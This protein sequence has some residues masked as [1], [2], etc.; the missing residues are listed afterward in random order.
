M[1]SGCRAGPC[2]NFCRQDI[3]SVRM[4]ICTLFFPVFNSWMSASSIAVSSAWKLSHEL[5]TPLLIFI[6]SPSICM[7]TPAPPSPFSTDPSV[8]TVIGGVKCLLRI[9][10]FFFS[11][12]GGLSYVDERRGS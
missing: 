1:L 10:S 3:E 9:S 2:F 4:L 8:Y 5:H 7:F 11:G 6:C 12:G